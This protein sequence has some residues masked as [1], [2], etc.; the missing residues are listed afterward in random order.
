LPTRDGSLTLEATKLSG[1]VESF[2]FYERAVALDEASQRL[3][4]AFDGCAQLERER[5]AEV[6]A[7]SSGALVR[8]IEAARACR[9]LRGGEV[10]SEQSRLE[11]EAGRRREGAV[12]S[13]A[14]AVSWEQALAGHPVR[15]ELKE[16]SADMYKLDEIDGLVGQAALVAGRLAMLSS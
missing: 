14:S 11:A 15:L 8:R 2:V 6:G 9:P 4:E 7:L 5:V 13:E 10:S 12:G 1:D 3:L 16:G